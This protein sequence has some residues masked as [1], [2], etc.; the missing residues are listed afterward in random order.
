MRAVKLAVRI[1][2]IGL[3]VLLA[4][5]LVC[6]VYLITAKAI[7]G[8]PQPTIFGYSAAVVVSGS[9][10]GSI[11]IDDLVVIHREESYAA[12]DVITF[13]SESGR[14][15]VTHRI[16]DR[17]EDGYITKGDANNAADLDPVPEERVVGR[18]V[19][20]IPK[21]GLFISYLRTPLGMTCLVL[22]GLLLIEFPALTEKIRA[23][24]TGG[25]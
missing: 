3:T 5:L 15:V 9:M 24:D 7:T 14:S 10:S 22:I 17:T 18:V 13:E 2:S 11:E 1:L 4:I 16:V 19:R 25:N 20:V 23:K 21:I 6:N 8:K 12:G